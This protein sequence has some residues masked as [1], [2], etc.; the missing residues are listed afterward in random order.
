MDFYT[1]LQ[2]NRYPDGATVSLVCVIKHVAANNLRATNT[3]FVTPNIRGLDPQ[4]W[5]VDC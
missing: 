5:R 3:Y 4:M 1:S 2:T